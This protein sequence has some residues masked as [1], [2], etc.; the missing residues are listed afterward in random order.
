MELVVDDNDNAVVEEVVVG[1][2]YRRWWG[3]DDQV[4]TGRNTWVGDDDRW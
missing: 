2:W 1:V 3:Y 4:V